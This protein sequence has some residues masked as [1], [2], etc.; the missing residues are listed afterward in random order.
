MATNEEIIKTDIDTMFLL[1]S[2]IIDKQ[3]EDAKKVITEFVNR[4]VQLAREDESQKYCLEG[5]IDRTFIPCKG[6]AVICEKHHKELT[7]RIKGLLELI[8]ENDVLLESMQH[9]KTI[10][11][12]D[13]KET[14]EEN[15]KALKAWEETFTINVT[16]CNGDDCHESDPIC[17][18]CRTFISGKIY[19]GYDG[20]HLCL[21][22]EC[23]EKRLKEAEKHG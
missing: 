23:Y 16:Y 6:F 3:P 8:E 5:S 7:D 13:V 2:T 10:L 18:D 12:A 1:V 21:C 9:C 17:S 22:S 15:K 19:C 20:K 4:K 14:R 11:K